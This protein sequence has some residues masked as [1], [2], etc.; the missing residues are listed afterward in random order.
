[1]A[2]LV[3]SRRAWTGRMLACAAALALLGGCGERPRRTVAEGETPTPPFTPLTGA[4]V[5]VGA[6]DIASCNATGDEA[7]AALL[8]ALP[9]TVFTAG[10]NV[11]PNG[12]ADEFRAC[13]GPTW[14]RHR[15][16]T[17]PVPGNHDYKST[18]AA[19]YFA[20]F[21][22]RAGPAG[23]GYYSFAL[24]DWLILMLNTNIAVGA[25]SEQADWLR[26][27]LA[28]RERGC[29][30]AISHHPRFSSGPHG[31]EVRMSAIWRILYDAGV[32]L[33]IAGHD[34][35]Y[36]RFAPMTPE[37]ALDTARG[38]RQ[39]VVGTGGFKP[40]DPR[41]RQPNSE[42]V[43]SA[44]GLI[45]LALGDGVYQWEFVPVPGEPFRDWG[46]ARCR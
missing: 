4:D 11:Y 3:T 10:D 18:G 42:V 29:E 33:A 46:E 15:A 31:S 6:G 28:G 30:I 19:P 5:L 9:G 22:E 40:Y 26:A 7:T 44:T 21:G 8:D 45:K 38:V 1:M 17:Y 14:G 39:F 23:K 37:G 27:Q 36:E 35:I 13:Y 16:R 20:Y 41:E 25:E 32:E 24:G 43:A 2:K 12:T 34:H